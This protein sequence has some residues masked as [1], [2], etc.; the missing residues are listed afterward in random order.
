MQTTAEKKNKEVEKAVVYDKA[1]QKKKDIV[2]KVATK[3]EHAEKEL[4]E[5]IDTVEVEALDSQHTYE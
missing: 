3:K 1:A 4:V 2:G 5:K